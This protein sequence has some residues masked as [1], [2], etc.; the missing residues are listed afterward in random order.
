MDDARVTEARSQLDH[1]T[2][3]LRAARRWLEEATST[4]ILIDDEVAII[5]LNTAR[6]TIDGLG[7]QL[8]QADRRL[9]SRARV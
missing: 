1:A 3:G 4:A 2:Q 7:R 6:M 9:A 8:V 5:Q